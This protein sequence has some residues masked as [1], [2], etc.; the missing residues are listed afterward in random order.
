[1][2]VRID[3][4]MFLTSLTLTYAKLNLRT[5]TPTSGSCTSDHSR[6]PASSCA[7]LSIVGSALLFPGLSLPFDPISLTC[8]L[9]MLLGFGGA[10][11]S[12]DMLLG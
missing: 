7:Y 3:G 12:P 11:T 4:D 10:R 5:R 9:A 2:H 1:M 8:A 6:S